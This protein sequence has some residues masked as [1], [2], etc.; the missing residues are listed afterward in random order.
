VA[1]SPTY[2]LGEGAKELAV[3]LPAFDKDGDPLEYVVV[4]QPKHGVLDGAGQFLTYR[5]GPEFK[6]EDVFTFR[7][8][9]GK[10]ISETAEVRIRDAKAAVAQVQA[11]GEG[12]KPAEPKSLQ[13]KQ[14]A[15][16]ARDQSYALNS[17]D[18]LTID[19]KTI[20]L[21]ANELPYPDDVQVEIVGNVE[22]GKLAKMS[23]SQHRYQPDPYFSGMDQ[24]RY[25]FRLGKKHLSK[26][27]T[28]ELK[29]ALG[30]PAPQIRVSGVR[31]TYRPGETAVIDAA[32]SRDDHRKSLVFA[33]E[34]VAGV[35]V[36]LQMLNDEGSRVG[37]I[38]PEDFSN[39]VSPGVLFRLTATDRTGKKDSQE[40]R[41]KTASGR[42][43][44]LRGLDVAGPVALRL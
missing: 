9:D 18:R 22:H 27:K 16:T 15:I 33:W 17:T 39:V 44:A 1:A 14:L 23:A 38:V 32:G 3:V 11:P 40:I 41:V 2:V 29:V 42:R 6:G 31:E 10:S 4:T 20:W 30:Q 7:A 28:V 8:N 34:Q 13:S 24:I 19:W 25:R 43:P 37:F 26:T 35:P 5:P 21:E 36:Q 12:D